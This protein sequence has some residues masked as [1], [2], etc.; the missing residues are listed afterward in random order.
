MFSASAGIKQLNV[1]AGYAHYT[2]PLINKGSVTL[3]RFFIALP[4]FCI[5]CGIKQLNVDAGYAHYTISS[6][7]HLVFSE[8]QCG[9]LLPSVACDAH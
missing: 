2:S 7:S 6:L 1:D 3:N 4:S 8:V 9:S 5:S